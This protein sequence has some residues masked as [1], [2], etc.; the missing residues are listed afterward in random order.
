MKALLSHGQEPNQSQQNKTKLGLKWI[1]PLSLC[2]KS[3]AGLR[4]SE[5]PCSHW[6]IVGLNL[7][8]PSSS[9]WAEETPQRS[10]SALALQAHSRSLQPLSPIP[11][12]AVEVSCAGACLRLKTPQQSPASRFP[13]PAAASG[14]AVSQLDRPGRRWSG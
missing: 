6:V 2:H 11:S 8:P 5:E 10:I 12:A 3:S 14:G 1:F 9:L 7:R 13:G 4:A